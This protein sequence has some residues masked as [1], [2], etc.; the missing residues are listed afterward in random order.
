MAA[1]GAGVLLL[2]RAV[3]RLWVLCVAWFFV[4][5]VAADGA[6]C[7]CC[8]GLWFLDGFF[9]VLWKIGVEVGLHLVYFHL[10]VE[11]GV[12][13]SFYIWVV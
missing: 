10:F 8:A 12:G 2:C 13:T 6:G 1:D 9:R 4:I 11:C 7:Y 5:V 3:V